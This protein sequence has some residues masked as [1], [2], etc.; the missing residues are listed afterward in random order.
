MELLAVAGLL[1]LPGLPLALLVETRTRREPGAMGPA[2]LAYDAAVLG[3]VCMVLGTLGLVRIGWF[4]AGAVVALA[5][6]VTAVGAAAVIM[7]RRALAPIARPNI[8]VFA[9]AVGVVITAG[10]VLRRDPIEFVFMIGDMGEYVNRAHLVAAGDRLTESFPHGFTTFLAIPAA[11]FGTS[12]T[13]AGLPFVGLLM[14]GGVARLGHVTATPPVVRLAVLALVALGLPGVWFSVFPVSEALYAPLLLAMAVF[15]ARA[16]VDRSPALAAVAGAL[17]FPLGILR[18]NALLLAPVA[19]LVGVVVALMVERTRRPS[20]ATAFT[21]SAMVGL[22]FAYAYNVAYLPHYFL[23][24]QIS[25]FV[26]DPLF[27]GMHDLRLTRPGLPLALALSS[28]VAVIS[29][30]PLLAG[31]LRGEP[32][33]KAE[34]ANLALWLPAAV[35]V[36]AGVAVLALDA[37]AVASGTRRLGLMLPAVAVAGLLV[38]A[39]LSRRR[40]TVFPLLVFAAL[41]VAAGAV[42]HAHRLGPDRYHFYRLYWD[43]Y[44]YSEVVPGLVV[45]AVVG[46]GVLWRRSAAAWSDRTRW[47]VAGIVLVLP[48]TLLPASLHAT[49]HPLIGDTYALYERLDG[50]LDDPPT[51]IVFRGMEETPPGWDFPNTHR[52]FGLP[53]ISFGYRSL[54]LPGLDQAFSPDPRPGPAEIEALMRDAGESTASLVDVG[55]PLTDTTTGALSI[56]YVGAARHVAWVLPQIPWD[57]ED[58]RRV[59]FVVRVARL[60]CPTCA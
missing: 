52:V 45:A 35:V 4:S 11:L 37:G 53:L 6:V 56:E 14:L 33:A 51:P 47:V 58:W 7:R 15:F 38:A 24:L 16:L 36:A 46:G 49:S 27:E 3:T 23:N 28:G 22:A 26:P 60:S 59:E 18:G 55:V 44:L 1:T 10:M 50:M 17:T 20:V 5:G 54:N 21:A 34:P 43:R 25:L 41:V 12:S 8:S 29:A 31:R 9:V 42:L 39:P 13:V 57:E 2:A 40:S 30:I 19:L 32:G 48:L